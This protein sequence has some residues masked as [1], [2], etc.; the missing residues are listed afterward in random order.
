MQNQ[1]AGGKIWDEGVAGQPGIARGREVSAKKWYEDVTPYMWLVLAIG[2]LGWVF[3]I[4]EGQI[5][6]A[7]MKEAM[8]A[9][10]PAGTPA[11]SVDFYNNIAMAAFLVGGALGGVVFGMI[12]DRIGRTTTMILTILMY[13]LF[14]CVT[15]FSQTWWQMVALRFLVA[16]GT[17]GEWAVAS[18]MIAEVFPQQARARSRRVLWV[19]A[20]RRSPGL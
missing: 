18:A 3:D 5:F 12:S 16:L 20:W 10:L 14:T 6:V 7:S 13:S 15:A 4:F 17:G 9:L 1:D 19:R 2:S 8:P 11:G